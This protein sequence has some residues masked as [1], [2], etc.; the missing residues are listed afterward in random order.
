MKRLLLTTLFCSLFAAGLTAKDQARSGVKI[1]AHRG[2]MA[3]RPENTLPAFERAVVLGADIL[4]LDIRTSADGVLFILH[5]S[6]VDR[7]TDGSGRAGDLTFEELRDLDAGSWFGEK[8]AGEKIPS[9]A[10]AL[11]WGRDRTTLLLDLKEL[12]GEYNETVAA[13]VLEH[14]RPE[15]VVIGVRTPEQARH[16][17][18]LLPE[19][20]Q[21]AFMRSPDLIDEFA[22]AGADILRLWLDRDGWLKDNP[23][24]ADRV[25]ATGRKLMINGTVGHVEEARAL[26]GFTP[27]WILIDD[28]AQLQRS[29]K[30]IEGG[31]RAHLNTK[32]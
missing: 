14:S 20:R 21:L 30:M 25:R 17:R 8:Y 12:T 18:E 2:G 16:F 7:T 1:V 9:F 23:E 27:D 24:L 31:K 6:R 11:E 10:E 5:D 32:R 22:E 19:A 4:E 26:I 15:A 3:D 29:L 28:A 13:E